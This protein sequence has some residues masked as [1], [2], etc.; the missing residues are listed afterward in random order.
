MN[1]AHNMKRLKLVYL[2]IVLSVVLPFP[3]RSQPETKGRDLVLHYHFAGAGAFAGN[4][5]FAP[6]R[7]IIAL[8]NTVA[9]K[10][11]ILGKLAG[12]TAEIFNLGKTS[13]SQ[14]GLLRPLWQD[15]LR[16]ESLADWRQSGTAASRYLFM[17]KLTDDHAKLWETN[18]RQVVSAWS[19]G[20]PEKSPA[21]GWQAKFNDGTLHLL[22]EGA[23]V[24]LA[25]ETGDEP[26][27]SEW[28]DRIKSGV[29]P[30]QFGDTLEWFS[31]EIN[32]PKLTRWLPGAL[33]PLKPARMVV[34]ARMKN[35]D[36][37]TTVS[38]RYPQP[39]EWQGESWK[40]P[41]NTIQWPLYSL[42]GMH[43]LAALMNEPESLSRLGYNP[44][45]GDLFFWAQRDVIFQV[46]AMAKVPEARRLLKTLAD[47]A[48]VVFNHELNVAQWGALQWSTNFNELR[49]LG[50]PAITPELRATNDAGVP[51]L[52]ADIFP[53][54]P[55]KEKLPPGLLSQIEGRRDLV[56]YN[57]EITQFKLEQWRRLRNLFPMFPAP[58]Q[59]ATPAP[60]APVA[61]LLVDDNGPRLVLEESWFGEMAP[62]LGESVTELRQVSPAEFAFTRKSTCGLTSLELIYLAHCLTDPAFP[63]NLAKKAPLPAPA[64]AV[65]PPGI[66]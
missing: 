35:G 3:A 4:T 19:A 16:A 21:G 34:S 22:R 25:F 14:A 65:G 63:L 8:T 61:M 64:A 26:P 48:P 15:I 60:T 55:G 41:T 6:L 1:N 36:V 45:A 58:N 5:N 7:Q 27:R 46:F 32:W 13:P 23:W 53:Q 33:G 62:L 31:A 66:K 17:I 40:L 54:S 47:K 11:E 59:P 28:I 51:Y 2:G 12:S 38:L 44:L 9:L 49:W 39:I 56:Y 52:Y 18:L 42:T 20:P 57:W 30:E 29:V 24:V 43:N 50:V 37:R 10:G